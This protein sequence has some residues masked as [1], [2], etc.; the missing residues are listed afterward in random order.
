MRSGHGK[1]TNNAVADSTE[2]W[3]H[4][5][6]PENNS[7]FDAET[8]KRIIVNTR[9]RCEE[10][11]DRLALLGR[12]L[13]MEEKASLAADWCCGNLP[14]PPVYYMPEKQAFELADGLGVPRGWLDRP[15]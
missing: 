13:T 3:P 5:N 11:A 2:T 10:K 4:G 1:M 7:G 9:I 15:K 14:H 8:W 6:I 12:E